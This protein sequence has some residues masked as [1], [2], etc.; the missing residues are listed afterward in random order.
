L[1]R[2]VTPASPSE[3]PQEQSHNELKSAGIYPQGRGKQKIHELGSELSIRKSF[4]PRQRESSEGVVVRG[5][6]SRPWPAQG[7]AKTGSDNSLRRVVKSGFVT[8]KST[9]LVSRMEHCGSKL[10]Q[11]CAAPCCLPGCQP[12]QQSPWLN[13]NG[14]PVLTFDIAAPKSERIRLPNG[15]GTNTRTWYCK[16]AVSSTSLRQLS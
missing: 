4:Q 15:A 12:S 5:K 16:I 9:I 6:Q 14:G 10:G 1:V 3:G 13:I 11:S 2:A 8:T 7:I